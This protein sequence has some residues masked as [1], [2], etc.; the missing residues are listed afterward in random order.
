MPNVCVNATKNMERILEFRLGF[1]KV[2]QYFFG[3]TQASWL[4]KKIIVDLQRIDAKQLQFKLN[5]YPVWYGCISYSEFSHTKRIHFVVTVHIMR[6]NP[7]SF[8]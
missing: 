3:E 2:K 4:V 5:E 6:M 1:V 7:R 8:S